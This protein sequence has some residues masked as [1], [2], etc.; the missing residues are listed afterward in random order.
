MGEVEILERVSLSEL[1]ESIPQR[2]AS[3]W[4]TGHQRTQILILIQRHHRERFESLAAGIAL[5]HPTWSLFYRP[6]EE[7]AEMKEIGFDSRKASFLF[8]DIALADLGRYVG[9][10]SKDDWEKEE[11]VI[12]PAEDSYDFG[13]TKWTLFRDPWLASVEVL[14]FANP[15]HEV[16]GNAWLT[17]P[18]P[19]NTVGAAPS[20]APPSAQP[21]S[22]TPPTAQSASPPVE[23]G[24]APASNF[25]GMLAGVSHSFG[26][27]SAAQPAATAG[28][29]QPTPPTEQAVPPTPPAEPAF[30]MPSGPISI[31][32]FDSPESTPEVEGS[33][34]KEVEASATTAGEESATPVSENSPSLGPVEVATPAAIPKAT[35]SP[36]DDTVHSSPFDEA[37]DN[38]ENADNADDDELPAPEE[39]IREELVDTIELLLVGGLSA[40]Q[41]MESPTFQEVSE[42]ANLAGLDVWNIFLANVGST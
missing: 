7:A 3:I 21:A 12:S 24:A 18:G 16:S 35:L 23:T 29:P 17:T 27:P 31:P 34:T 41:I 40:E 6:R 9:P 2:L 26:A 22:P 32:S 5:Q 10:L 20:P 4:Q 8:L 13:A 25:E 30:E 28:Q 33:P 42:R 39:S 37:A 15:P 19:A 36:M 14:P 11:V 38:A 1:S